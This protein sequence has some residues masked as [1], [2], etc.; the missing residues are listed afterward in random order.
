MALD[1]QYNSRSYL[2]GRLLAI[3]DVA[4]ASTYTEEDKYR[5]TNAK[6][7]MESFSNKPYRTWQIIHNRLLPYL[8]KM[9][10]PKRVFYTRLL[11]DVA[12]MF[13]T[14]EFKDNAKLEPEYLLGYHCQEKELYT[15]KDKNQEEK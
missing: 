7:Y 12:A 3:A 5:V 14:E 9:G 13:S 11:D 4:E 6:R 2:Y 10:K 15:K 8:G 1:T